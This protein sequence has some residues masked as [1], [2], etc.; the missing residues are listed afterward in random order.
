MALALIMTAC[1]LTAPHFNAP[2]EQISTTQ[3]SVATPI[4][5]SDFS[6]AN[7]RLNTVSIRGSK[8]KSP[9]ED[10]F[11]AYLREALKQELTLAKKFDANSKFALEGVI[12]EQDIDA[13]FGTGVGTMTVEFVLKQADKV[14]F[15]KLIKAEHT[16]SSSFFGNIAIPAAVENY[17]NIVAQLIQNLMNDVEFKKALTQE[18]GVS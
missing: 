4:K 16:W 6:L 10:S 1:Q 15:K 18:V 11:A 2:L 12:Q 7:S 17:P 3:K 5:L 14:V 9:I 13:G 8:L